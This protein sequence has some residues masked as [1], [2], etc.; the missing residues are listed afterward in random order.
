MLHRWDRRRAG[1]VFRCE[2]QD[3][4]VGI[5]SIDVPKGGPDA[6]PSSRRNRGS[7]ESAGRP[8]G[9]AG[10]R[11]GGP[12]RGGADDAVR[13]REGVRRRRRVRTP[14]RHRPHGGRP[15]RPAQRGDRQPG[16]RPAQ[17]AWAWSSSAPRSSSS[18]RSTR[19]AATASCCTASTIAE[20]RSSFPSRPSRRCPPG[21]IP[22]RA[23][24]CSSASATRSWT[25]AGRG[26]V[27][28]TATRLGANLPVAVQA[29]G[30]PIVS[31]IRIEYPS[32]PTAAGTFTHTLPLKGNDRFV[33]YETADTDTAHS[34]LTVRDAIDG[35]RRPVPADR[36][37]FGRCPS[38]EASL[39]H[40]RPP[41][42]ACS[43]ASIRTRSMS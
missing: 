14:R 22:S 32:D 2:R 34:T 9:G 42:S 29:D 43:T 3:D 40:P 19:P 26:D 16:P 30:S 4:T 38:G 20:T 7:G 25:P 35:E 27:T 33:S 31:R 18:S 28:T 13:R 39:A 8:A 1:G 41:T 5:R 37:A 12:D 24:G 17:R 6:L 36:W 10:R 11:A 15:G 23:T 21:P